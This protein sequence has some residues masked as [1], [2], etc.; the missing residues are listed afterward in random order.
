MFTLNLLISVGYLKINES[1]KAWV[2]LKNWTKI[3]SRFSSQM[4]TELKCRI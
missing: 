2:F 3:L 1:E 4:K